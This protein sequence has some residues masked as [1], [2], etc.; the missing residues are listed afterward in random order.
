MQLKDCK[1]VEITKINS[2]FAYIEVK[3]SILTYIGVSKY[4]TIL[5]ITVN[6]EHN[7]I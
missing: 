5:L 6:K 7:T 4:T 1:N 3:G 2:D